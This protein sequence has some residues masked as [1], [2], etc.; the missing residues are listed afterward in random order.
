MRKKGFFLAATLLAC[1][2]LAGISSAALLGSIIE[3]PLIFYDS[4]GTTHYDAGSDR[5]TVQASPTTI[6]LSAAG[7]SI[8]F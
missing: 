6:L 8:S 5:F 1:L 4:G 3:Y 2:S 7:P